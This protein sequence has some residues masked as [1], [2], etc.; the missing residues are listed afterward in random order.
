LIVMNAEAVRAS[1]PAVVA[2]YLQLR[3]LV[4]D[5]HLA[6]VERLIHERYLVQPTHRLPPTLVAHVHL[7]FLRP[8][9]G[10]LWPVVFMNTVDV[11]LG[12]C[13]ELSPDRVADLGTT[14]NGPRRIRQRHWE[15]WWGWE[16]PLGQLRDNFFELPAAAQEEAVTAWYAEHLEWLAHNGL[17]RRRG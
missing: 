9:E 4:H 16:C 6:P 3:S 5:R 7:G 11:T 13:V 15:G 1:D 10:E 12:L 8:G 14:L 17:L 2:R